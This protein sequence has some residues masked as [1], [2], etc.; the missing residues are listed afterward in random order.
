MKKLLALLTLLAGLYVTPVFA[1]SFGITLTWLDN[2]NNEANFGIERSNTVTGTFVL[3]ATV[4]TNVTTYTDSPLVSGTQ[5]CY[6]VFAYNDAGRSGYSNTACET[7][8]I[9]A[10]ST[11]KTT[12]TTMP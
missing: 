12:P 9:R 2:S 10:P 4:G 7:A 1:A 6:R 11:L 5:Y 8:G 3:I